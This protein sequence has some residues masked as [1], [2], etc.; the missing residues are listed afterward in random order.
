VPAVQSV[1]TDAPS[2]AALT[3][4]GPLI[5]QDQTSAC[6]RAV[7]GRHA[8]AHPYR[9]YPTVPRNDLPLYAHPKPQIGS[10]LTA[11]R[12]HEATGCRKEA[13]VPGGVGSVPCSSGTIRSAVEPGAPGP[14]AQRRRGHPRRP[15]SSARRGGPGCRFRYRNPDYRST[16]GLRLGPR[17]PG[18]YSPFSAPGRLPQPLRTGWGVIPADFRATQPW[19]SMSAA[20]AFS[21]PQSRS[22]GP[23]H[24][25]L[26]VRRRH[27]RQREELRV[28]RRPASI[29][30][31][32]RP[33]ASLGCMQAGW[34]RRTT[35][36]PYAGW[37]PDATCASLRRPAPL[38]GRQ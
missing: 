19:S 23:R 16:P 30:Q 6:P 15:G 7:P 13:E 27:Q 20:V 8:D 4:G 36:Q 22:A 11:G 38:A 3:A 25:Q 1:S 29:A 2:Q 21:S 33:V 26:S 35:V 9:P 17:A 10:R 24:Q 5:P 32:L 12:A 37:S 14:R 28:Q 31:R 34:R 18:H